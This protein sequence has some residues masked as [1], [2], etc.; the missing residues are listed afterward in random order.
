[1]SVS[2]IAVVLTPVAYFLIYACYGWIVE[3]S[4]VA[5]TSGEI[6]N[7]GFLAGP[8]VPIYGVGAVAI[9]LA[10]EPIADNA[11]LVFI[12]SIAIGTTL[13]LVTG[14]ALE[15][16]F[17]QRWWDYSDMP[18]NIGGYVCPAYS[19]YWGIIGL[20]FVTAIHR[21]TAALVDALPDLVMIIGTGLALSAFGTDLG[22]T[23][24]SMLKLKTNLGILQD[25]HDHWR[26]ST[27]EWSQRVGGN[28]LR[29]QQELDAARDKLL[30]TSATTRRQ[31][32][33]FPRWQSMRYQ[34]ALDDLRARHNALLPTPQSTDPDQSQKE[35]TTPIPT[36]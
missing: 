2:E 31:L 24:H 13:E 5:L 6:T 22:I 4:Y 21:P 10:T 27:D 29:A 19:A 16:L 9:W 17:G 12:A 3:V 36:P 30:H 33:A 14:W 20:V 28:A 34:E 35:Q 25:V 1:M 26:E 15:K 7:R 18:F 8:Y 23:V 11:A 32:K